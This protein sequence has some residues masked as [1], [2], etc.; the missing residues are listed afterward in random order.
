MKITVSKKAIASAL[1]HCVSAAP[2]QSTMPILR[3][4]LIQP[5]EGGF[6]LRAGS[7]GLK[8]AVTCLVEGKVKDPEPLCVPAHELF[9]RVRALPDGDIQLE[10]AKGKLTLKS[11]ARKLSVSTLAPEDFPKIP[12]PDGQ[13]ITLPVK[14]LATA[15]KATVYAVSDE[16]SRPSLYGLKV[17]L[18]A[19]V[20]TMASCDS[21]RLAE[22]SGRTE[23][24][25]ELVALVPKPS[26]LLLRSVLESAE[27]DAQILTNDPT[28]FVTVGSVTFAAVT[29]DP[30][31]FPPIDRVIPTNKRN[32]VELMPAVAVESFRALSVASGKKGDIRIAATGGKMRAF[33]ES[34]DSGESSDEFQAIGASFDAVKSNVSYLIDALVSLGTETATVDCGAF[35]EPILIKGGSVRAVVMPVMT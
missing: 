25:G 26:A 6:R 1:Q 12:D 10:T 17:S 27:G 13:P 8:M 3:C 19:G 11:G 23:S 2:R 16:P 21:Y 20:L 31:V 22:W 24:D 4:C 34:E 32:E 15:I 18:A 14:T 30:S 29:I 9:D 35:N 33:V 7:E 5:G 28:L